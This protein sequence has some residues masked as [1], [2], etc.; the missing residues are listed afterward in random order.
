MYLREKT[1]VL[2]LLSLS[3]WINYANKS[4]GPSEMG[5]DV[6]VGGR[7]RQGQFCLNLCFYVHS[8]LLLGPMYFYVL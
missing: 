1:S 3:T 5:R 8:S 7:D 2:G 6:C 4:V